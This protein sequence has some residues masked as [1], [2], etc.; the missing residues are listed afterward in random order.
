MEYS[1]NAQFLGGV[2]WRHFSLPPLSLSKKKEVRL[3]TLKFISRFRFQQLIFGLFLALFLLCTFFSSSSSVFF[4]VFC[5]DGLTSDVNIWKK[6]GKKKGKD[7][8]G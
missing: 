7:I 1:D 3:Q 6:K 2:V 4:F 5:Q 8:F